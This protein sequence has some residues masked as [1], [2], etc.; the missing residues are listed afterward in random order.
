MPAERLAGQD[1]LAVLRRAHAGGR[2]VLT[3]DADFGTLAVRA[4]EP[5]TG[6]IYLRPGHILPAVTLGSLRAIESL[7]IDVVAPFIL[8]AER[9][10]DI[11]RVRVRG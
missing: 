9:R 8:V 4:R 2:V 11:V 10:D 7:S 1:D 5:Y 3:H 6:I